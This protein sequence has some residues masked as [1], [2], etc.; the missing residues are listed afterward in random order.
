MV[1]GSVQ[2]KRPRSATPQRLRRMF[3]AGLAAAGT[4]TFALESAQAYS[5]WVQDE[6]LTGTVY[7]TVGFGY[8]NG[9]LWGVDQRSNTVWAFDGSNVVPGGALP[10]YHKAT[11]HGVYT[12]SGVY[13]VTGDFNPLN[14]GEGANPLPAIVW[15]PDGFSDFQQIFSE[16]IVNA[17]VDTV[18]LP[19][20]LVDLGGGNMIFLNYCRLPTMYYT[21]DAGQNWSQV[22]RMPYWTRPDAVDRVINHFHGAVYDSQYQTLYVMT[23]DTDLTSSILFTDDLYGPEGLINAPDLWKTRWGLDDTERSTLDLN[24]ALNI[25]GNAGGQEMRT[26]DITIGGDYIY[27]GQDSAQEEG[28]RVFRAHRLT[29]EVEEV[30]NGGIVG[31]VRNLMTTS[32]GRVLFF[33]AMVTHNGEPRPGHDEYMHIYEVSADGTE[34]REIAKFLAK[35]Y[36][37]SSSGWEVSTWYGTAEAFGRLWFASRDNFSLLSGFD[38]VEGDVVGWLVPEGDMDGSGAVNNDDITPF[39]LA[40]ADRDAYV[41]TYGL[42]PDVVGDIDGSGALNNNDITP[43]V[44]LLTGGL[45]RSRQAET[46]EDRSRRGHCL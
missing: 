17:N 9:N 8:W 37:P 42:D 1:N 2:F 23:G 43:F 27:W 30:G 18:S 4:V 45:P 16:N 14:K 10:Q 36:N 3:F 15:S 28:M 13:F 34:F 44:E 31:Q 7:G 35:Y 40:L 5:S 24:Y 12:D 33:T 29:H 46:V 38:G 11:G 22:M 32:D 19:R 39:V 25:N 21:S 6:Q 41:A 20:S 26:T